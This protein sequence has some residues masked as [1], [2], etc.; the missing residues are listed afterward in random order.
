MANATQKQP[1]GF[2]FWAPAKKRERL[3]RRMDRER[4]ATQG[5][6]TPRLRTILLVELDAIYVPG[7]AKRKAIPGLTLTRESIWL[8]RIAGRILEREDRAAGGSPKVTPAAYRPCKCCKRPLLGIAA[9]RRLELDRRYHG[10]RIPC[11]PECAEIQ[12]ARRKRKGA[13]ETA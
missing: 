2:P 4:R 1:P 9:E 3:L 7:W 10:D 8:G 5:L 6:T 12:A 11:S 13:R